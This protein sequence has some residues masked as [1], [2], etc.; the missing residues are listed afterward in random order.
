MSV[1]PFTSPGRWLVVTGSGAQH[2]LDS[3]D[4][5]GP[6]TVTRVSG[7][8]EPGPDLR[9]AD[10]RR[11]GAALRVLAVE[12]RDPERGL[13]AGIALGADMYLTLEPL[14]ADATVTVRRTTPVCTITACP[15]AVRLTG[16]Q[17]HHD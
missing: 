11:D 2:L 13:V 9:F 14:A 10:L 8:G 16:E 3:R 15:D 17:V 12:H 7:G 4:P 6:V 1:D 5:D